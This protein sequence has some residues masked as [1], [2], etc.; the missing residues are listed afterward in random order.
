MTR[1]HRSL[2][3]CVLLSTTLAAACDGGEAS[4]PLVGDGD[5]SVAS[6]ADGGI[7]GADAGADADDAAMP[8]DSGAPMSDGGGGI[9]ILPPILFDF[10]GDGIDQDGNGLID[11]Q[12]NRVFVV[13]STKTLATL[14]SGGKL[15]VNADTECANAALS[16]GYPGH[17]VAYLSTSTTSAR[18][19]LGNARGFVRYD[20]KPVADTADDFATGQLR[21]P[22]TYAINGTVSKVNVVTASTKLGTYDA[23]HSC[24]GFT[25]FV[26]GE[27]ACG[28]ANG[29]GA[30]FESFNSTSCNTQPAFYCVQTD[31]QMALAAPSIPANAHRTFVTTNSSVA[32]GS[33]GA[34]D[35]QCSSEAASAGLPGTYVAYLPTGATTAASRITNDGGPVVRP[36]GVVVAATTQDFANLV[37]ASPL[38]VVATGAAIVGNESLVV[39]A[40]TPGSTSST[41]CSN[42]SS[43]NGAFSTLATS[44][45]Y[46]WTTPAA[47]MISCGTSG[48][49]V[50]CVQK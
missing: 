15:L 3:L 7:P 30:L 46:A 12:C 48:V 9:I 1:R 24:S 35:Q 41:T 6:N 50:I 44:L 38:D 23:A 22:I 5:A 34:Y 42:W 10:C 40:S 28:S 20:R 25:D 19:R 27:I 32:A 8:A 16:N 14:A 45:N 17:Y 47:G 18:S 43:S 4:T 11:D 31:Y 2:R 36:D 26:A 21:Y 33:L 13:Q 49:H 37:W 39:G 29:G